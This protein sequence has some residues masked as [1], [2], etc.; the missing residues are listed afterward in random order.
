MPPRRV[1]R[2]VLGPMVH[3]DYAG[4]VSISHLSQIGQVGGHVGAVLIPTAKSGRQRVHEDAD[5]L[6]CKVRKLFIDRF[7]QRRQITI[8]QEVKSYWHHRKRELQGG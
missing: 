5:R 4:A 1:I 8:V 2:L 6:T 3:R 7:E